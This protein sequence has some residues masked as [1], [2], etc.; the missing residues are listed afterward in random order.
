[1]GGQ[2]PYPSNGRIRGGENIGGGLVCT[3]MQTW[4]NFAWNSLAGSGLVTYIQC[5]SYHKTFYFYRLFS[6]SS[7][8]VLNVTIYRTIG[9]KLKREVPGQ[10]EYWKCKEVGTDHFFVRMTELGLIGMLPTGPI[11]T[12]HHQ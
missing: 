8:V 4:C 7:H 2:R 6:E 11:G 5:Y 9:T 10:L 3:P 12:T 1:M